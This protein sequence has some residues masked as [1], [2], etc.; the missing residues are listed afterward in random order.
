MTA[1]K[2]DHSEMHDDK[3]NS[4][5]RL[6]AEYKANKSGH[7]AR[8]F[9]VSKCHTAEQFLDIIDTYSLL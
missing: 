7:I 4:S 1:K 3:Q 6:I 5:E 8:C 9:R 2:I